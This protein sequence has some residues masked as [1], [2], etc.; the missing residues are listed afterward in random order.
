MK[1]LCSFFQRFYQIF[2]SY[3]NVIK[4]Y[5]KLQKA[6]SKADSRGDVENKL[7][8]AMTAKARETKQ[9]RPESAT[10]FLSLV[11]EDVRSVLCGVLLFL[12]CWGPF[13]NC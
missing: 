9:G 10:T 3:E 1:K 12:K 2:K 11:S 8:R 13:W 6:I 4:S 5:K 7:D